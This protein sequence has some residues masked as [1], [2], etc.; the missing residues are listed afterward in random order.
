[1]ITYI[2]M[3]RE[4]EIGIGVDWPYNDLASDECLITAD[5]LEQKPDLAVGD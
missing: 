3:D 5:I 4:K 2:D 1:M